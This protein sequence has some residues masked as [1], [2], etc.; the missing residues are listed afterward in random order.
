M[1]R[2]RKELSDE[3]K[4]LDS[5]WSGMGPI[6]YGLA[7]VDG[8]IVYVGATTN[9]AKRF[10]Y[11][12]RAKDCHNVR[13][14]QWLQNNKCCVHIL[15]KGKAG[16][17]DAERAE[18]QNR[19]GLLNLIAGGAQ[20]WRNHAQKPWM[21]GT[22]ILCPSAI[23]LKRLALFEHPCH[24]VIKEIVTAQR[25]RMTDLQRALYETQ[26][27]MTL[28]QDSAIARWK[29]QTSERMIKDLSDA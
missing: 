5:D 14:K 15:H 27:A 6:V 20:N 29:A 19:K 21:A 17:F 2:P 3:Q 9:P 4:A 16:L 26:V 18:I 23:A 28:P 8:Q 12:Q 1:A 7:S 25:K 24:S 10:A 11:Y 22:G 13:L